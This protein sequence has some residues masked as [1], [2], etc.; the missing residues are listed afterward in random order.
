MRRTVALA[1]AILISGC[2]GA[3][4]PAHHGGKALAA[5]THEPRPPVAER[6][7]HDVVSPNGTRADPY[8][9]LR[10]DTRKDP[11]VLAYLEAENAYTHA[12]LPPA[13]ALE[14]TLFGEIRAR[15]K[16]DD[17]DVPVFDRGAWYYKRFEAG[18]QEPIYARRVGTM[19]APEEILLDGPALAAGQA[20][21]QVGTYDVSP[22]GRWLAWVDDTVGRREY[23]LHVKDLVGGAT[24][25]D[26]ATD[27]APAVKWASDS[28]TLFYVGK[29]PTTLREDR[30]VRHVVGAAAH[31]L[32]YRELDGSY[33]VG[34]MRTK[35][36]R[37][38]AITLSATTNSEVR[39]I[40]ADRPAAAPVV[41]LPRTKDHEY[42]VDHL[43][44]R[45]WIRTNAG[46]RD[47]RVVSVAEGRQADRTA[48]HDVIPAAAD[49]YVDKAVVFHDFV[50][51]TVRTGGLSKV[52]VVPT[53][54]ASFLVDGDDASYAM[55]VVDVPDPTAKRVR[56]LY[57]S[58]VSPTSTFELDVATRQK[59]RLRQDPVPGYDPS[60]YTTAYLHA[61][62]SDGA[63][64]PISVVHKKS[65]P[66]DGTA[67]L[68]IYGYGAYGA[69]NDPFLSPWRLS[70]LDRGWVFAMASVRGGSELGR[71]WYEAGKLMSKRNTFTDFIAATEFLAD[72]GYGARDQLYARGGSAGGI[73]MGAIVNLRPDLY[74]GVIALVPFVDVVTTML[75][76]TI[77]LTTNE[78][79]EWGNPKDP[80]AYAYMLSYSPYDN[81]AAHDYPSIYVQTGLWDSQVQYYE[82]T[83]WVAKLRASK[84]DHNLLLLD[85]DLTS[86]HGGAS[87]RFDRLRQV[88]RELAFLLTIHDRPDARA[89]WPPSRK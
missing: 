36:R 67:P 57:A 68:L 56:Y 66:I 80:A 52:L 84:T 22:D 17:T 72:H 89:G 3:S 11:D 19:D 27:V 7:P 31:E 23:V 44:G 8:Y 42:Q 76:D 43:D 32:V 49:R 75:D 24:L 25:P 18:K 10:D 15:M 13:S 85:V 37:Y 40:D 30:I 69:A 58:L 81:V 74:R 79:D 78:Y 65:T 12:Y 55:A 53:R 77:P 41:F 33:Y 28:K 63:Q 87:G 83:K 50:A 51:A 2:G 45:F 46:A 35:S 73:L 9:W 4:A 26:T 54:G 88:A 59:E 1:V 62:A 16:E 21:F 70:L 14:E 64:I 39:L 29:D 86:G 6:R 38:L 20:Y 82:P 60:Q 71:A 61:T 47:F 48:W 5:A 34:L